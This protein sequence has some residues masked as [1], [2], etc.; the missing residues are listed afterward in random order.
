MERKWDII[1]T[2]SYWKPHQERGPR[3]RCREDSRKA[4]YLAMILMHGIYNSQNY[5]SRLDYPHPLLHRLRDK[6]WCR[7]CCK[8]TRMGY[9]EEEHHIGVLHPWL[10]G[11]QLHRQR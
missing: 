2:K 11:L 8:E 5:N 4:L 10:L 3:Q 7:R 6:L 1:C 9:W